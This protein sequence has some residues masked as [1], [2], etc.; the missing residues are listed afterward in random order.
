MHTALESVLNEE[1]ITVTARGSKN[2]SLSH[3]RLSRESL[4]LSP[5]SH[6][7]LIFRL[8]CSTYCF[9]SLARASLSERESGTLQ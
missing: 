3:A 1:W 4:V 2:N 7:Q 9:C 8:L 6:T 5:K